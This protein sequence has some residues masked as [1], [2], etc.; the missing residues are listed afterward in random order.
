M[1]KLVDMLEEIAATSH[2]FKEFSLEINKYLANNTTISPVLEIE[3][4]ERTSYQELIR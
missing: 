3:S 1:N 4:S 2:R